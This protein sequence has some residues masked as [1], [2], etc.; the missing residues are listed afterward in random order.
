MNDKGKNLTS[1]NGRKI[2]TSFSYPVWFDEYIEDLIDLIKK[3]YPK[4][5]KRKKGVLSLGIRIAVKEYVDRHKG[6]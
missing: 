6:T 5:S 1:S 4:F 3:D 2:V